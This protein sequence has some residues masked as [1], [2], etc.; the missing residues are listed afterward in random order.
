[1]TSTSTG[2]GNL[3]TYAELQQ[4]PAPVAG[5]SWGLFGDGDEL[6][7]LNL[8]TPERV[9]AAAGVVTEGRRF[10][11]NLTLDAFN[12]PLIAHRG[13]PEHTIFGLNEF[14]RDDRLDNLFMQA[15][16][17]IDGLRHFGHPDRGFYGGRAGS[18]VTDETP[19]LG[20][21]RVA[22]RGIVGRGVLLDVARF[23]EQQGRPIN[24]D[25]GEAIPVVDLDATAQWQ[26]SDFC[27]G[28]ILLLRTGW[29][30]HARNRTATPG[31]PVRSAGL[32]ATEETAAWLW[33]HHF[34]VAAADNIALEAWPVGESEVV[35]EAESSGALAT[36]SHTGMLH[37]ILIPLLGLTIG[38]LW[39]L[40]ELAAACSAGGRH[41]VFIS[42]EPL[43]IVGGV[44][45]PANALAIL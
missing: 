27:D 10:G 21:Q 44:G 1:M 7:T 37:R 39:D 14:H 38:E 5:T 34:S 2:V 20:L 9:K 11:L 18:E 4:R 17:Q 42:A 3:P 8:L 6:G 30:S 29:L 31:T 26:G 16:T 32:A 24:H 43:N 19:T 28:D 36:N 22:E 25:A 23:R 12:P 45:S 33:D 41:E 15:S 13:N 40:D 35:T